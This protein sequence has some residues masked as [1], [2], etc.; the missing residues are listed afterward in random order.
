L[1][2]PPVVMRRVLRSA[3][4]TARLVTLTGTRRNE[5]VAFGWECGDAD[6][7]LLV[8]FVGLVEAAGGDG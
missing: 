2:R 8:G 3:L 7:G 4:P 5:E 6:L 1:L